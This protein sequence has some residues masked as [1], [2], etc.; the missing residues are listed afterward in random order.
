[1]RSIVEHWLVE[2]SILVGRFWGVHKTILELEQRYW[3]IDKPQ[4][5]LAREFSHA[6]LWE[7][8]SPPITHKFLDWLSSKAI[9][10][11][12]ASPLGQYAEIRTRFLPSGSKIETPMHSIWAR[13]GD[14]IK[15]AEMDFLTRMATPPP[16]LSAR[17]LTKQL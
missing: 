11:G 2:G 16:F 4:L 15:D 5:L 9:S 6:R 14:G 8:K 3:S 10:D 12:S 7:L 1:M 13:T 17:F